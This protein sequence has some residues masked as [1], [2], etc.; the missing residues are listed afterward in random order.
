MPLTSNSDDPSS[1]VNTHTHTHAHA[2]Y[3]TTT[4]TTA[5]GSWSTLPS[6]SSTPCSRPCCQSGHI[7]AQRHLTTHIHYQRKGRRMRVETTKTHP[8]SIG[9]EEEL[10]SD[11]VAVVQ[12]SHDLQLSVLGSRRQERDR[13]GGDRRGER[14]GREKDEVRRKR[15][16]AQNAHTQHSMLRLRQCLKIHPY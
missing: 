4:C 7:T 5:R 13:T 3:H 12:S 11:D 16:N 10:Q 1:L 2:Q 6:I 14:R 9:I 15:K 8:I